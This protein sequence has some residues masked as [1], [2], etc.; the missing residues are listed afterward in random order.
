MNESSTRGEG[1]PTATGLDTQKKPGS[2]GT[3]A[4]PAAP[5]VQ[6]GCNDGHSTVGLAAKPLDRIA[7]S[8]IDDREDV[9]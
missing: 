3:F 1:A 5:A 4:P 6:V 2:S 8:G 9:V 7:E